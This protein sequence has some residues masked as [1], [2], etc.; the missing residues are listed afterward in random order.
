LDSGTEYLSP[1]ATGDVREFA[2]F[3]M[4]LSY[5]I[6]KERKGGD[7]LSISISVCV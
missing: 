6:D 7:S 3:R 2:S 4:A 1:V 5:D